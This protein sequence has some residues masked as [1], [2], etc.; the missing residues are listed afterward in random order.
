MFQH[1]VK[2][3]ARIILKHKIY[4]AIN[5]LGLAIGLA[6]SILI[7]Q[8]VK[9]ELSFDNFHKDK[10]HIFRVNIIEEQSGEM[11]SSAIITAGIGPSMLE[12]LPEVKAMV[13]LSNP[14]EGFFTWQNRH[15]FTSGVCHADSSF[16]GMFS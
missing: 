13:R 11:T 15:F 9:N 12:E 4:S 10:D 5:I 2:T 3:A 14:E 7:L 8:Y 1:Y 6:C 16:F